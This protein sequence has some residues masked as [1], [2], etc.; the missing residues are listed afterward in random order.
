M[1]IGECKLESL[2]NFSVDHL[3]VACLP[4][5]GVGVGKLSSQDLMRSP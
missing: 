3:E 1:A 4:G 5:P 2:Y